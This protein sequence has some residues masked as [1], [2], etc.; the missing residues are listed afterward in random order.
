[1]ARHGIK[2]KEHE[3]LDDTTIARVVSLL[4]GENPITKKAACETLNISYNTTRLNRIIQEYKDKIEFTKKRFAQNKGKAFSDL[5]IKE[6]VSDY[7][8][9][10]SI[11]KISN[12]L[13]RTVHTVKKQI[14]ELNLPERTTK[15]NYFNPDLIPDE[16]VSEEFEKGELVWSARYSAVAEVDGWWENGIDSCG[17][18]IFV[19]GKHNE[20]AY[21]PWWELGKLDVIKHFNLKAENFI[22]TEKSPFGY[23][24]D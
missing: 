6:L 19:F 13:Y 4:E 21:Q 3:R 8:N 2:K 7:L 10:D 5:E 14:K 15:A 11:T 20:F 12:N 17:Y 1:M 18:R 23:R 24:I 16:A 22:T 9:G